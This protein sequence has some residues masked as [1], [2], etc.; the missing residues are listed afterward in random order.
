MLMLVAV[1]TQAQTFTETSKG[2]FS[3]ENG[4]VTGENLEIAGQPFEVEETAK[5]AQYISCLS[6]K[7]G[8]YY[9]VWIGVA[10]EYE[11]ENLNVRQSSSGKYFVLIISVNTGN[12]YAKYLKME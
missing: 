8:N 11:H 7:T 6:P 9:P 12:P 10:T 5:G 1:A 3:V 4:T 2:G